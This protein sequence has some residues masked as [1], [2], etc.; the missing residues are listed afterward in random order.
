[1][2]VRAGLT[3]KDIKKLLNTNKN[4]ILSKYPENSFSPNYMAL[5]MLRH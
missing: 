4:Q 2:A 1:L 3:H 5:K